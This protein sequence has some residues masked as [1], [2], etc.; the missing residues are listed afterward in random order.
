MN[1]DELTEMWTSDKLINHDVIDNMSPTQLQE[2]LA[3]LEEAGL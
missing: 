2:V 3:I 1:K